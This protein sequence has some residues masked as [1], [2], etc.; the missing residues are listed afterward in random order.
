M[1]TEKRAR[2]RPSVPPPERLEQRSIRLTSA[3]WAKVESNGGTAWLRKLI[4][5][6]KRARSD[7]S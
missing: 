3:Q 7:K 6:A 2:G 5:Q 4:D 1:E